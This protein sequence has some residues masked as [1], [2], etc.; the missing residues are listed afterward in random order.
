[1]PHDEEAASGVAE[2]A[3]RFDGPPSGPVVLLSSSLGT[4]LQMWDAQIPELTRYFRVLRYDHRGHG[5][6]GSTPGPCSI[7][8]LAGDALGLLD[9]LGIARVS[10]VGLSLGGMVGMWIAAHR[11]ERLDRLVLCC[12][13]PYLGPPDSWVERA[14]AVRA[15]GT[16]SL[17]GTLMA[18]WFTP[19]LAE[20]H[21]E[22]IDRFSAML[23]MADDAGYAA[24]CEAI[25]SMDQRGTI[26]RIAAPTLVIS[27]AEDP[28]VPLQSAGDLAGAIPGAALSVLAHARHMASAEQPARF[29]AAVLDHLTGSPYERGLATRRRVLGDDYVDRA[30][31]GAGEHAVPFQQFLTEM[32]WGGVWARPHLATDVRR[33]VTIAV[34]AALGRSEE[35]V[36]HTTAALDDGV[37]PETIR[38]VLLQVAVYGGAP[39]ANSAFGA[40]GVLLEGN[41]HSPEK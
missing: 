9:R 26:G 1:M 27:G 16:S 38:E 11:P 19:E 13:A 7:E 14:A 18:R 30:I 40:V 2:L 10:F 23:A 15:G 12:T 3:Y 17:A 25:G 32:A 24:C 4:S 36:A 39:A 41:G 28:V 21:P 8:A 6:S 33:I 22:V 29:N 35:L 34:L 37:P 31:G 20:Q 5:A